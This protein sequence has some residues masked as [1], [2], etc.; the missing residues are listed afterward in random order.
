M[1]IKKS[2][3]KKIQQIRKEKKLSQKQLCESIGMNRS[4]LAAVEN[5]SR[6]ITLININKLAE[7]LQVSLSELFED[8]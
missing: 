2:F 8:L 3:G 5:G 6:N 4:Y 1:E 7:G